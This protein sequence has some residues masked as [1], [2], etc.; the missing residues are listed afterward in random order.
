MPESNI[1]ITHRWFEEVW[2][3]G[4][5]S[6]IDELTAPHATGKG[7]VEHPVSLD[8]SEFRN[9]VLRWRAAFPDVRVT[10]EDCFSEGDKVVARWTAVMTHTGPFAG[11]PATNRKVSVSGISIQKIEN[12]RIIEGWD[13]WDQYGLLNQIGALP[14]VSLGAQPMDSVS[15]A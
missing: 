5:L 13:N 2:N 3:Q 15:V 8:L 7:Q 12:A 10:I 1:E 14:K 4:R 11:I 6:S 9:F